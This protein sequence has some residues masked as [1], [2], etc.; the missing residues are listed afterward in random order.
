MTHHRKPHSF[1]MAFNLVRKQSSR[2]VLR[3]GYSEYMQQILGRTPMP[4]CDFRKVACNFIE[5]TLRH[6]YSPENLVHVFR[7]PF[8][9]GI[10]G[11]LLL[12]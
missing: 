11:G 1:H 9:K 6:G 10:S 2:G 3:K 4:K 5:I 7:T 8:F 12:I